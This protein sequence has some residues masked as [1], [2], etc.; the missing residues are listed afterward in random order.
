MEILLL[1]AAGERFA[2]PAAQVRR[3][4]RAVA[5]ASLPGAPS[6]IDG[7]IDVHGRVVPVLSLRRRFGLPDREVHPDDVLVLA[8]VG[9][10]EVALR[11]D[12]ALSL[13]RTDPSRVV[14]AAGV[15][16]RPGYAAGVAT[17]PDGV[18]VIHDLGAFL[19]EA[20]G[21]ALDAA[22]AAGSGEGTPG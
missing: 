7:V 19:D 15:V 5:V 16:A 13:A 12:A 6:A 21:A 4:V 17:L 14:P 20:E 22:L 8:A 18:V 3:V 11:V 9:A 10:R 1:E 2:L